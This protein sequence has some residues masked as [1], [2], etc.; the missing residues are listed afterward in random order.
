MPVAMRP[1]SKRARLKSMVLR[2]S[3][4]MMG[5][6]GVSLFGVVTPPMLKPAWVQLLLEVA[7]VGPEALDA[8]G[9]ACKDVEGGDAAGG[10]AGR[11]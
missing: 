3:P 10:D 5:V 1:W 9:L 4:T 11:M 2:P 6:M 7:R 8:F